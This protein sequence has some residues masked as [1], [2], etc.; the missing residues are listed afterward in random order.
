MKTLKFLRK[1]ILLC[2]STMLLSTIAFSQ[3]VTT[4]EINGT[5]TASNEGKLPGATIIVTHLPTSTRN[6]T[7]TNEKGIFRLPNLNVGGPYKVEINFIGYHPVVK[8]DIYL[9]L[10]QSF[11]IDAEIV[12]NTM[13]IPEVVVAASRINKRNLFDGNRTGAET[14]INK[15]Q[16]EELPSLSGDLSDFLR[17]TP[18]VGITSYGGVSIAGAN[19]RYN[20]LMV[21]GT[22]NNDVFGLAENG[23]NGGQTGIS[24]ISIET[25]DQ[26]QVVIAPFDVRQS[27]FS[28]G[29]INAV[30]K[31][32]TNSFKGSLYY[33]FR[34]QDLAGKTPGDISTGSV[35]KKLDEFSAKQYGLSLGGPI[36]KNKLFFFI[37]AELQKDES[38]NP[39][40]FND[41]VGNSG[42]TE[43]QSIIDKVKSFGYNP[44]S[45]TGAN[46]E[47][48]G[49]KFLVKLN[50]NISDKHRLMLRHQYTKGEKIS[51]SNSSSK[52]LYF[53][54]SGVYFP[55]TT[56]ASA[57]ELS[58]RFSDKISNSFKVGYTNVNDNRDPLG[59]KFPGVMISDGAGEIHLGSEIYSSGN[60]LKQSI[61]TI[62]DNLQYFKGKHTFTIGTHNE[63][64]S[65]YNMFMRRA[66]GDYQF[67]SVA[68]FL[69][70]NASSYR[71]G[72]SLVD[73]IRGD[74]SAAAADFSASQIGFY[75]QDEIQF[76][77]NFKLTAGVRGDIFF[78]NDNPRFV[79]DFNTQTI[80]SLEKYYDMKGA[81]AGKMPSGNIMWSPRLG[82]NWDLNG[83]K[84]TQLRGGFGVFTSRIPL[85]WLAASY[86]NNGMII[87]DYKDRNVKFNPDWATQ[88]KGSTSAPK[89]SQIDLYAKNFKYP[90]VFRGNLAWDQKFPGGIVGTFEFIYT[91]T[92]NNVLW[93][94]VNVK[95]AWGNATGTGDNR[96]LY[97]TYKNGIDS[98]YGQIMLGDN[99]DRGYAYNFTATLSKRFDFGLNASLS[100]TFGEAKS[101]FDGTSSQNSS[102][103]NYLVSSPRP[104]NMAELGY[105]SF[106]LGSRVVGSLS[107][108]QEWL[109]HLKT[110]VSVFYN[111]QSGRRFSYIYDDYYGNF[112]HEA[113]KSPQ[114]IYIPK[115]RNDIHLVD[116]KDKQGNLVSTAD[117]QWNNLNAFIEQNDYLKGRRGKYAERNASRLPWT[118]IFDVKIL[119]DIWVNVAG[120]RQTIQ[121]GLDIF[122]VGNLLNN[123]WGR[124]FNAKNGQIGLIKFERMQKDANGK[125][126]IPTFTY[127]PAKPNANEPWR[128]DDSGLQSSRWKAQLTLRYIF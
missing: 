78:F 128:L 113:Y 52:K 8:E 87:G 89:G 67:S 103:W 110:T 28:G 37:N 45:Y 92:L 42:V 43:L 115:D 101:I 30:T 126:T 70:G 122:N 91:R 74:G 58:S 1:A 105:S 71:L 17:A 16:I 6:G 125:Y 100:Y 18:Q 84:K 22:V 26:F 19:S 116:L 63:F 102:Q 33:K 38:P 59:G 108:S 82:F 32:G 73:D 79:P 41:Y 98:N 77:D 34:N 80:P 47:L 12:P 109:K 94:D 15:E 119:Q 117:E 96:P 35:R 56:H 4:S 97:K 64:Y 121:V 83:D 62:T 39:Y 50:W 112:T 90:Q 49:E 53:T 9:T 7:T 69:S 111:G 75:L 46:S 25:I 5:V 124:M 123:A 55:S 14:V 60:Q 95:P 51:P 36:V 29:G 86:T 127:T 13:E 24:P 118:N 81:E 93:K 20:S 85:V 23:M 54:N 65:I 104:K 48:K 114:L 61:F 76:N 72:Y 21:D 120:R 66:F 107:Y 44:G 99:T 57:L 2:L 68:D 40:D 27:G 11:K 88:E 106:D 31:R 3:G 10:G